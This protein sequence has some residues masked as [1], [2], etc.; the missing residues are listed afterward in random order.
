[1]KKFTY[2]NVYKYTKN[3]NLVYDIK[4]FWNYNFYIIDEKDYNILS[5]IK[6]KNCFF[7]AWKE[8]IGGKEYPKYYM[9]IFNKKIYNSFYDL[10]KDRYKLMNSYYFYKLKEYNSLKRY[11]NK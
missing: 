3:K 4:T 2:K 10:N 11:L 1:M 7:H 5:K 6:F 8:I 9:H